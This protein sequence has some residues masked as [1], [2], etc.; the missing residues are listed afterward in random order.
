LVRPGFRVRPTKRNVVVIEGPVFFSHQDEDHFFSW[1]SSLR[2]V[3]QVEGEG[4]EL[5]ITFRTS[6]LSLAETRE[7]IAIFRR[8][9]IDRRD[10]SSLLAWTKKLQPRPYWF[11]EVFGRAAP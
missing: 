7:L 5:A 11:K 3:K 9:Q 6:R 4:W 8:Y 2:S 10:L 1:L